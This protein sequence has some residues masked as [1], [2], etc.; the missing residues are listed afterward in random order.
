MQSKSAAVSAMNSETVAS[1]AFLE[2]NTASAVPLKVGKKEGLSEECS[3]EDSSSEG[4]SSSEE[5]ENGN[6]VAKGEEATAAAEAG[7]TT[8]RM[9]V[10]LVTAQFL[11]RRKRSQ[12]V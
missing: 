3:E 1:V 8:A 6:K 12:M 7:V 10:V 9:T 2:Y 11:L 5:V 4:S